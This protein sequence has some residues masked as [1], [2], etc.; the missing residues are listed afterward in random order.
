MSLHS[1]ILPTNIKFFRLKGERFQKHMQVS[2]LPSQPRQ[3]GVDDREPSQAPRTA[4]ARSTQA[5]QTLIA[6][7]A[8]K[9]TLVSSDNKT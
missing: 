1:E 7:H 9:C 2:W 5:F 3:L 4:D 6:G 8:L